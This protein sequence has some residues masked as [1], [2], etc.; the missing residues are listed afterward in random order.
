MNKSSYHLLTTTFRS[1]ENKEEKWAL[2]LKS[3]DTQK[4]VLYVQFTNCPKT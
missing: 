3:D 4:N 2:A 1:W